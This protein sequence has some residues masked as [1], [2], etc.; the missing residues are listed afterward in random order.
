[1]AIPTGFE[2]VTHGVEIRYSI[3]LSYGTVGNIH[4]IANMKNQ[5]PGRARSQ[6]FS[7]AGRQSP[8]QARHLPG[9]WPIRMVPIGLLCSYN[10]FIC[11]LLKQA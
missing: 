3:Q 10:G 5:L 1:V 6:P 8:G 4:T 9:F 7:G 2:P 11:R